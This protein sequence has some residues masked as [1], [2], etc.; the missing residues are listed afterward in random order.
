MPSCE[1]QARH[2]FHGEDRD[3]SSPIFV[4][5]VTCL[6]DTQL[7]Q[8]LHGGVRRANRA[9]RVDG[10][11]EGVKGRQSAPSGQQA[12]ARALSAL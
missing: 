5:P 10:Q 1:T 7:A 8:S 3:G 4:A 2:S 9:S 12:R 6:N 11:A